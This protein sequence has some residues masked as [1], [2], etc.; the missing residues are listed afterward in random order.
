MRAGAITEYNIFADSVNLDATILTIPAATRGTDRKDL[1][2]INTARDVIIMTK[3]NMACKFKPSMYAK[4]SLKLFIVQ[5]RLS[6]HGCGRVIGM[7]THS[8]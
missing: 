3:P 8:P 1:V 2:L 6:M 5:L 4:K 7:I